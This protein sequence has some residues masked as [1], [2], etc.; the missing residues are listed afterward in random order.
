MK[1][2]YLLAL[3]QA[4]KVTGYT[5][6]DADTK[7]VLEIGSWSIPGE[8]KLTMR[9]RLAE[10][11]E[12]LNGIYNRFPFQE[13]VYEDIQLQK[14]NVKTFRTLAY[15][16]AAILLWCGT[17]DSITSDCVAPSHWRSVLK[18][19]YKI[20]WGRKRAEQKTAA[21]EFVSKQ[22][23]TKYSEDECD[24]YCIG[25]AYLTEKE[26]NKSAF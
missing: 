17:D 22:T 11:W 26:K 5:I 24:S 25:L 10:F 14:T 7:E 18:E 16:Q 2:N 4:S 3:D 13:L 12:Q 8:N 1:R 9:Q 19:K 6:F 21:Q 23:G 20:E 15:I